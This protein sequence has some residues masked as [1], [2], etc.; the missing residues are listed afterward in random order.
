MNNNT[1]Y[2]ND[3]YIVPYKES[4]NKTNSLVFNPILKKYEKKTDIP[5]QNPKKT[6]KEKFLLFF[7]NQKIFP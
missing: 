2:E 1:K 5:I 7:R 4:S 3:I 6:L